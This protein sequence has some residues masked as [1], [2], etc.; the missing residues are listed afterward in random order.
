MYTGIHRE[1]KGNIQNEYMYLVVCR[2]FLDRL[3]RCTV[4]PCFGLHLHR[5]ERLVKPEQVGREL[6]LDSALLRCQRFGTAKVEVE[7]Q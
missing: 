4:S 5:L 2:Q 1:I 3:I 7:L 6:G